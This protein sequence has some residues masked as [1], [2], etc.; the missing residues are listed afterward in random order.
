[1]RILLISLL[2]ITLFSRVLSQDTTWVQ[3]FT[4]DSITNRHDEFT[5]P[6]SLDTQRFEKVLMYYKLKC[7]PLTTWDQY[8][9]GE[10]D[11]LTYTRVFDHT[12]NFDSVKREGAKYLSNFQA[13]ALINYNSVNAGTAFSNVYQRSQSVRTGE[14]LQD[15]AVNIS[16]GNSILPFHT[17]S[18]GGTYQFLVTAQELLAAGVQ[19]GDLQSLSL[20][21]SSLAQNEGIDFPNISLLATNLSSLSQLVTGAFVTVYNQQVSPGSMQLGANRFLFF[22]PFAWNGTDNLIVQLSF[23]TET[24]TASQYSFEVETGA[25]ASSNYVDGRNGVIEFD[26][27][28]YSLLELS[29]TLIAGDV[30]IEFWAKGNANNGTNT[31][32]LEAYDTLNNRVLNIHM[33]W[34][35]NN[36][37]WDAGNHT[38]YDRINKPMSAAEIDN[39]WNHWAFVKKQ[40]TGQMFIY[41]NGHTWHSGSNLNRPVGYIHRFVLGASRDYGIKWKGQV[42]EFRVFKAAL[43]SA[44]ILANFKEKIDNTH[45]N[46]NALMTYYDFDDVNYADDRSPNDYKLMLSEGFDPIT[47]SMIKATSPVAGVQTLAERPVVAFGQGTV[48]GAVQMNMVSQSKPIEPV[49]IFEQA[50]VNRHF[51]IVNSYRGVPQGSSYTF[52]P[53]GTVVTTSAVGSDLQ[54]INDTILYHEQPYEIVKDVE[55]A[56][57]ITPYG[58]NFDLGPNGFSWIYDVTDYQQY[59]HGVVDLAAHN[60]QELLDLKFAFIKG[61]PPRDVHKREPIWA[62][63]RSYNYGQMAND[64]VLQNKPVVLSDT[65]QMFKIKTRMSGHGQVGNMACCEWVPNDHRISIDG[66]PRFNWN[67]WQTNECGDNPNIGQGGT[68]P[69]A[70]EGWCPGDRVKDFDFELTPFIQPGD[71]VSID[72]SITTVP[73]GDPGTAGGNYIGAFDLISYSAPNFQTDAAIVDVLNPNNWEYYSKFNPTCS[74]PRV[75]L[76]NTGANALT[77]CFIRCWIT[78]GNEIQFN[79][80]GNLGFMEEEVVEIPVND[81]GFWMDMDSTETFTAYVSNV[82]GTLGNDEYLQ[83]SVKQVKFDAPEVINGPFFAWLTTNNKAVENSYKLI[84]GAGNIIFQRNQL[85]NQTQYKDTFDLAPGCYS[86]IIEDTDHDGLSFWYSAQVEGET[87]GQMR[88]RYVGGSY[89]ELF[90]GDFGHYHRYDFSVGFGVG[91]NENKL[92]HEIA[93]FPNPTSGETTIEISGFVDNEATLEIYDM[94]GRKWLTEEMTAS[95]HFAESHVNLAG[96]PSG[97]YIARIVTK[98]QVYTKQFVKQ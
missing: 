20:Y 51:E 32:I 90:P 64:L 40:S 80:T 41:K 69:Y 49:V 3:T 75:V 14:I 67:I 93:V 52:S 48:S 84:D 91:L 76:R 50:A 22:Q 46:Y 43:D 82:N 2:T 35:N 37:Y 70:R 77:S 10:W 65:S 27:T 57:Y 60:T 96:V 42:D 6:A 1:M 28:N 53:Q 13:P 19:A 92:D 15:F 26:G 39:N 79:W 5:F 34:S 8:D 29:D 95:Q 33:P 44:T 24:P 36:I 12:G 74:N 30:T 87:N 21:V 16:N 72:Y 81:L 47:G 4:F 7:S 55:I 98:N 31:T 54:L 88:L 23:D 94:M 45:P 78:Y 11:Y 38:G 68:W 71:T 73:P 9:C 62:D 56:R 97:A 59:L 86:I 18:N 17:Q 58:I 85:A 66:T 25:G 61:I 83:N 63:W 89:I